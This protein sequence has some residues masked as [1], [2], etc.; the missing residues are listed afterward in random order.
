MLF[1]WRYT[2][3]E[4]PYILDRGGFETNENDE[5]SRLVEEFPA[6]SYNDEVNAEEKVPVE[7]KWDIFESDFSTCAALN[8][9]CTKN[10]DC[11][12]TD[13]QSNACILCW[14]DET[15]PNN[16]KYCGPLLESDLMK[17]TGNNSV[18]CFD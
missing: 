6:T 11:I 12:S 14:E 9:S 15:N 1:K 4:T 2:F 16:T 5:T 3:I 18:K 10:D 7:V 13:T 17:K 8:I